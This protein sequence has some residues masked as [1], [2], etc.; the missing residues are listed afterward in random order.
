MAKS[1]FSNVDSFLEQLQHPLK[2]VIVLMAKDIKQA[3]PLV[4]EQ[5]KWNSPAYFFE[6]KIPNANPK[7]YLQDIV[8]FH[9][10]RPQEIL[11]IFP[12]GALIRD[13]NKIFIGEIKDQRRFI[14]I[15]NKLEYLTKKSSIQEWIQ[16][17]IEYLLNRV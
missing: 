9:L 16:Q 11:L 8:V 10:R 7:E 6:G 3:H 2:E 15:R 5:I 14:S 4:Q 17:Y 13:E 12:N 1:S